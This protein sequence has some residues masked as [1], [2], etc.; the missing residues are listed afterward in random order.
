MTGISLISPRG[1]STRESFCSGFLTPKV[2]YR[3]KQRHGSFD[4][5]PKKR[6]ITWRLPLAQYSETIKTSG[7]SAHIPTYGLRF[8]WWISHACSRKNKN[9]ISLSYKSTRTKTLGSFDSWKKILEICFIIFLTNFLQNICSFHGLRGRYIQLEQL[10][11]YVSGCWKWPCAT[12]VNT[13]R[14]ART[15]YTRE[16]TWAVTRERQE[17]ALIDR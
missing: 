13:R 9:K 6:V 8:T 1:S 15:L 16:I 7:N 5:V 17:R 11:K 14:D 2:H 4:R 12:R 10:R 3:R